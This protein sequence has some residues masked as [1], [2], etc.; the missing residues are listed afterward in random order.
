MK[1]Q[2][3][4]RGLCSWKEGEGSQLRDRRPRL[5]CRRCCRGCYRTGRR[6]AACRRSS[7]PTESTSRKEQPALEA[8]PQTPP[9][10]LGTYSSGSTHL[11]IPEQDRLLEME[12]SP[13][14][15]LLWS[16]THRACVHTHLAYT[17]QARDTTV[18]LAISSTPGSEKSKGLKSK[19]LAL[20][21]P[22]AWLLLVLPAP[23]IIHLPSLLNHRLPNS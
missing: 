19:Y 7:G 23:S 20:S 18:W 3:Q 14:K 2:P 4:L 22:P 1:T 16:R 21:G 6:E 9:S 12:T 5:R 13:Q 10:C 15:T 11:C 8:L 17:Q